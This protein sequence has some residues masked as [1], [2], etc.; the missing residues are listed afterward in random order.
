[1]LVTLLVAPIAI[2]LG[3]VVLGEKLSANAF[4][5]FVILAVG[6]IILDERG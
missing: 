6:L 3:A 2:T 1:M 5:G 4:V